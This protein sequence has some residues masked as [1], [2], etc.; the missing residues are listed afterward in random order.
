MAN[1]YVRLHNKPAGFGEPGSMI[2]FSMSAGLG[3]SEIQDFTDYFAGHGQ[4]VREL[5]PSN[6]TAKDK[7]L[8]FAVGGVSY[9]YLEIEPPISDD[10]LQAI[11]SLCAEHVDPGHNMGFLIDNR[12]TDGPLRPFD[13]R[14]AIVARW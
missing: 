3:Q 2:G 9:Q 1:R 14:G 5:S 4:Q 12:A 7:E 11:G 10:Q 8:V 6:A 13:N